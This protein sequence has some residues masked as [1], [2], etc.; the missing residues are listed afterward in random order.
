MSPREFLSLADRLLGETTEADWRTAIS[1]AYYAAFHESRELLASWGFVIR[2]AD[3]A[4]TGVSRR[5][6]CSGSPTC[7]L[8]PVPERPQADAKCCRLRPALHNHPTGSLR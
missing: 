3:Q 2:Q 5:L 4:H 1:R 6:T 8:G 7:E